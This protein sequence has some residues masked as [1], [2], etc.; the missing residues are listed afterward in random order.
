MNPMYS[1][2]GSSCSL[3]LI[4]GIGVGCDVRVG[5]DVGA[6]GVLCRTDFEALPVGAE[7][8]LCRTDFEALPVGADGLLCRTDN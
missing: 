6:E 3:V 2:D 5:T 1:H 4:A 8:V 7:G